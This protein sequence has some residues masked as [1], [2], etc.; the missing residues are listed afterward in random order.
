MAFIKRILKKF[1]KQTLVYWQKMD[2]DGF[3]QPTY[4]NPIQLPCRWESEDQEIVLPDKRKVVAHGYLLMS[5][6]LTPGSIVFLGTLAQVNALPTIPER[7]VPTF[8][9]GGREVL[10]CDTTPDLQAVEYLYEVYV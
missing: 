9:Q 8:N 4:A 10:K 2:S 1:Q 5:Q 7:V 6:Y 3:G